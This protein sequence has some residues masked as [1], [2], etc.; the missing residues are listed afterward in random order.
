MVATSFTTHQDKVGDL[1]FTYWVGG[2]G[3]PLVLLHGSGPGA[4]TQGYWR[5]L[6][7]P[8]AEK[9]RVIAT[10]L[11]GFG[12]SGRKKDA[13]YFDLNLWLA[14]ICT[15][16]DRLGEP[17]YA[18]VGHSVSAALALR[19]A[20][21]DPRVQKVITTSAMG[22]RSTP[23]EHTR[24]V[25]SYPSTLEALREIAYSLFYDRGAITDSYLHSRMEVLRD[26]QYASY[27][28]SMFRGESQ[29]YIDAAV[30]RPSELASITCPVLMVHGR[31][32]QPFPFEQ[33]T[34]EISRSLRHADIVALA[35]CGH[36]PA[37]EH[38]HR[39]AS[40]IQMFLS[41]K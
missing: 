22:S 9:Y 4:S 13:P 15:I 12:L 41:D 37:L 18:V 39:L 28:Q 25:W 40:L 14:Q 24:R 31:D 1:P 7:E 2:H 8:L 27:F 30:V 19:L 34:L 23:N 29:E 32:D 20:A 21:T 33:T 3:A 26:P 17:N 6:L 36:S 38:P 5:L 16:L 35:K 11:I 10:D